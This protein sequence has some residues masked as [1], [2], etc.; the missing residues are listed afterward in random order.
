MARSLATLTV[1]VLAA[2]CGAPGRPDFV[3]RGLAVRLETAA[4]FAAPG[5]VRLA[6]GS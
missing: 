2:S 4:P 5:P 1:L 3:V 6:R